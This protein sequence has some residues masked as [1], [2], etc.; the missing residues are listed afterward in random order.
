MR[1]SKNNSQ[2]IV[3]FKST[4]IR[5]FQRPIDLEQYVYNQEKERLLEK[6]YRS[7]PYVVMKKNY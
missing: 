3:R 1:I 7:N 4:E 5:Y 6:H 2:I